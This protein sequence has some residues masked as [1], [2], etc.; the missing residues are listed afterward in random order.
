MSGYVPTDWVDGTTPLDAA[1]FDNM[2]AGI[3]AAIAADEAA[4]HSTPAV[5]SADTDLPWDGGRAIHHVMQVITGGGTLRTLGTPTLGDGTHV[6]IRNAA[7]SAFT[8]IHNAAAG[9]GGKFFMRGAS[10]TDLVLQPGE[11]MVFFFRNGLWVEEL[12]NLLSAGGGGGGGLDWEGNWVGSTPY[13]KGDVVTKDGVVYGAVNDSTGQ[14]PPPYQAPAHVPIPLVTAL[15]ATPFDGQEVVLTDSLTAPTYTWRFR[16]V[17]AKAS[18]KW[19]FVGGSRFIAVTVANNL[20][21]SGAWGDA[22]TPGPSLTLPLAGE[23]DISVGMTVSS[24]SGTDVSLGMSFAK[25]A[26][27]ADGVNAFWGL[28]AASGIAVYVQADRTTR[29]TVAAPTVL[30]CKY[31]S[32]GGGGYVNNRQIAAI[33]VAV[34]G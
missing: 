15:P 16:Y 5:G 25:G 12:R 22:S 24:G 9:A 11:I 31:A 2:E 1:R 33:P 18:N 26:V 8:I 7:A 28:S 13:V 4:A 27:A 34:G 17:A 3:V 30:A 32:S 23:Y 20:I 6:T 10:P 19:V 29:V 14:T 21:N